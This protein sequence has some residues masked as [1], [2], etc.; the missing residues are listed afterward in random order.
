M[1]WRWSNNI[2]KYESQKGNSMGDGWRIWKEEKYCDLEAG[3]GNETEINITLY[4]NLNE[5]YG[6]ENGYMVSMFNALFNIS[7]V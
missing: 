6:I 7:Y 5:R 4:G 2:E 1:G 3:V